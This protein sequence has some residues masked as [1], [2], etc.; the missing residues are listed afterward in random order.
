MFRHGPCLVSARTIFSF[1]VLPI[2]LCS[3]NN[4]SRVAKAF[5]RYLFIL[6]FSK[7]MQRDAGLEV[8]LDLFVDELIDELIAKAVQE[9]HA[10]NDEEVLPQAEEAVAA[11]AAVE[12]P[13][14]ADRA[15]RN[16]RWCLTLNAVQGVL[17]EPF[18]Q[19]P[20][21]ARYL[22]FQEE[23][24]AAGTHHF[25]GYIEFETRIVLQTVKRRLESSTVHLS[26]A[27]ANADVNTKYCSKCCSACF[28]AKKSGAFGEDP[29]CERCDRKAG[30]WRFG[31]PITQGQRTR[32][33]TFDAIRQDGFAA[34]L[35]EAPETLCGIHCVA[36]KF[37]AAIRKQRRA[38]LG[39]NP[40]EIRV[41]TGKSGCGKSKAAFA[42][43]GYKDTYKLA[44]VGS[45]DK[46]WFQGYEGEKVVLIEEFTSNVPI[47]QLNDWFDGHPTTL[48]VKFSHAI[49]EVELWILCS[50]KEPFEWYP[51]VDQRIR[52]ALFRRIYDDF[53]LHLRFDEQLKEF[54][55]VVSVDDRTGMPGGDPGSQQGSSGGVGAAAP[56]S[57][58]TMPG[59][60]GS[61]FSGSF[62]GILRAYSSGREV[63]Y[64]D[65][66]WI[67][68][69]RSDSSGG[70]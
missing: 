26:W 55:R 70:Q 51:Y 33:E 5:A 17:A 67:S 45:K 28:A 11:V 56:S 31:E 40:P 32:K 34:V 23:V 61:S 10:L 16:R 6:S 53:G 46:L 47:T 1:G 65:G 41:Y 14:T 58:G 43:C 13:E 39:F 37:D 9:V 18:V 30:P 35:I 64:R 54:V 27:I 12:E 63:V 19:L 48:P 2:I 38:E 25:Q 4:L 20:E 60:M 42:L 62:G 8:D 66:S 57:S 44:P 49:S 69:D 21:G 15:G 36:E 29:D 24:G 22:V 68:R 59:G 3:E 50:N 52:D 7:L